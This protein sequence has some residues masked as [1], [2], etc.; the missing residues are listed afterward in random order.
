M[1]V[2]QVEIKGAGIAP[3]I[4]KSEKEARDWGIATFRPFRLHWR[5]EPMVS[6]HP[7][8]VKGSTIYYEHNEVSHT[9]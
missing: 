4:F 6:S 9:S 5:Q 3:Y 2:W 8:G 7:D 1:K